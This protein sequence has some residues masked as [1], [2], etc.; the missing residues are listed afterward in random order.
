MSLKNFKLLVGTKRSTKLA[1]YVRYL[2]WQGIEA[3]HAGTKADVF[4]LPKLTTN[5]Q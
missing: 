3:C 5:V 4:V 1:A 2:R